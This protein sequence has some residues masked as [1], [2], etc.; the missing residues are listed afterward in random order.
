V[1][2]QI[3][4]LLAETATGPEIAARMGGEEFLLVFPGADVAEAHRRCE[5]LRLRI[6]AHD[7][8]PITGPL[9]VTAS[10]GITTAVDGVGN[11]STLLSRADHN[12]YAAKRAGRDRV[13]T[14][15]S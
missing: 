10:I 14:D 3:A 1:L 9:P 12:L 8:A 5:Q 6:R 11:P 2:Q 7:W 15:T 13:V 4:Q